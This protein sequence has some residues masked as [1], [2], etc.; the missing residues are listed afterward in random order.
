ME[1]GKLK[2]TTKIS[3]HCPTGAFGL[4]FSDQLGTG[5]D[6][7]GDFIRAQTITHDRERNVS[8][9]IDVAVTKRIM[10]DGGAVAASLKHGSGGRHHSVT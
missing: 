3:D 7:S 10:S 1:I 4:G 5:Q 6:G 8:W 9:R 2:P